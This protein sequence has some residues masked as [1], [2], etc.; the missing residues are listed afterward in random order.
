MDPKKPKL[1]KE[2]PKLERKPSIRTKHAP[3]VVRQTLTSA[4]RI[5]NALNPLATFTAS[6]SSL[7]STKQPTGTISKPSSKQTQSS[8]VS[9]APSC[10]KPKELPGTTALRRTQSVKETRPKYSNQ[11]QLS[12][13]FKQ[14]LQRKT[15]TDFNRKSTV[16][17]KPGIEYK[18]QQWKPQ[19]P[20]ISKPKPEFKQQQKILKR[21]PMFPH[22]KSMSSDNIQTKNCKP[23][24]NE[25]QSVENIY[26]P[27]PKE[28]KGLSPISREEA[29]NKRLLFKTPSAY[30]RRSIYHH[31][32]LSNR[33]FNNFLIASSPRPDEMLQLQD[34]LNKWLRSRG[35]TPAEFHNLNKFIESCRNR[36]S[37]AVI[38]EVEEQNKENVEAVDCRTESYENLKINA[39]PEEDKFKIAK[40]AILVLR[41]LV[42][43]GY[44]ASESLELLDLITEKYKNFLDTPEYWELRAW[45]DQAEGNIVK[46]VEHFSTAIIQGADIIS[47]EKSIDLLLQKFS[48]LNISPSKIIHKTKDEVE[49][50]VNAKNVFK[51]RIIMFA[52]KEREA[53]K[54]QVTETPQ[55]KFMAIPVRRSTRLSTSTY[56]N[57][58]GVTLY[59]SLKQA[60]NSE[61]ISFTKNKALI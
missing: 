55:K 33:K 53:K 54:N 52:I 25:S 40:E 9:A 16:A 28:L 26:M 24:L 31:T 32:P 37:N 34:R 56:K 29:D 21:P 18:R 19:L 14:P 15:G 1:V 2:E 3:P 47:V 43:Q 11:P 45:I 61:D 8:S 27:T 44:P 12:S 58:P 22:R 42:E 49:Q 5:Q 48:V 60:D 38:D 39:T 17:P 46:A 4:K 57:S 30:R 41:R 10:S 50:R 7:A 23:K 13:N 59:Q 6:K 51:S 36:V 35:K 20:P